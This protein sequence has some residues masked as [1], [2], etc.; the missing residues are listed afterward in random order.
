MC[1]TNLLAMLPELRSGKI[2][3]FALPRTLLSGNLRAA[4]SGIS[5]ASTCSSPSKSASM[6]SSCAFFS[7]SAVAACTL[8]MDGC[9]ALPFVEKE[10]KATRGRTPRS[11]RASLA[12]ETATSASCSTVGSGMT[13]QSPMNK[14]PFSPK[15]ES[16]T[17]I[18]WQLDALVACGEFAGAR[19]KAV[20]L[21]HCHHHGAKIV[22]LHHGLSGFEALLPFV[23]AQEFK[24]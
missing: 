14:T 13:P 15:P 6:S 4:I 17:S 24:A 16:S 10:S 1:R 20:R 11:C 9:V 5:A 19:H 2:K 21:V 12:V 22:R 8:R 18:T 23:A 3:T 7:A